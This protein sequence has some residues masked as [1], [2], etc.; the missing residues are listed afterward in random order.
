M[1]EL[2]LIVFFAWFLAYSNGANDNFKGVATL[3]GSGTADYKRA[4]GWATLT[5]FAG[6]MVSLLLARRSLKNFSGKGLV[7]DA[8]AASSEFL[9]AV[10]LRAGITNPVALSTPKSRTIQL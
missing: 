4:L 10:A 1:A 2:V 7:P 9:M 8:V 3:F 5:T 6:S